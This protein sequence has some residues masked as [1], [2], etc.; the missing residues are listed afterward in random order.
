M[1]PY[2]QFVTQS[3]RTV[4]LQ[5][6]RTSSL[7]TFTTNAPENTSVHESRKPIPITDPEAHVTFWVSARTDAPEQ[8]AA[9]LG[10]AGLGER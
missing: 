4:F 7:L 8:V 6:M 9:L 3:D 5:Q 2:A 10:L 1:L